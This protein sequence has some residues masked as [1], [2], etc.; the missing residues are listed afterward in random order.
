MSRCAGLTRRTQSVEFVPLGWDI[1]YATSLCLISFDSGSWLMR[2]FFY[3]P[4]SRYKTCSCYAVFRSSRILIKGLISCLVVLPTKRRYVFFLTAELLLWARGRNECLI[5]FFVHSVTLLRINICTATHQIA[6]WTVRN[7]LE[8]L[9]SIDKN[10]LLQWL[11]TAVTGAAGAVD[12][13]DH[14]RNKSRTTITMAK[15]NYLDTGSRSYY[16]LQDQSLGAS[17]ILVVIK[18]RDGATNTKQTSKKTWFFYYHDSAHL[19]HDGPNG[20]AESPEI[21]IS[22]IEKL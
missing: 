22:Y 19:A 6:T 8:P 15:D 3:K 4:V 1:S 13:Y 10:L 7:Y 17:S 16:G 2:F 18:P 20:Q 12:A 14:S 11:H 21:I 9:K 5:F